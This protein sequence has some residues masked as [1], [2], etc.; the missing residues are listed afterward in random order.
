MEKCQ[1]PSSGRDNSDPYGIGQTLKDSIDLLDFPKLATVLGVILAM[2]IAIGL[3][4]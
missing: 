3:A 2:V 4:V 1:P